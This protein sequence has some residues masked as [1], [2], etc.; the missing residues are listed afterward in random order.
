[1]STKNKNA[2]TSRGNP[3]K[4]PTRKYRQRQRIYSL[5][6]DE[7]IAAESLADELAVDLQESTFIKIRENPV[8]RRLLLGD[9]AEDLIELELEILLNVKKIIANMRS[10]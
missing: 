8:L 5:S 6:P 4:N 10:L 9:R 1:M 3:S 7:M 2:V